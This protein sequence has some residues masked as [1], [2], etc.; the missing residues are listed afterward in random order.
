MH[1]LKPALMNPGHKLALQSYL[2]CGF[3]FCFLD[4]E[5]NKV[6]TTHIM[7]SEMFGQMTGC[8]DGPTNS[9]G[10]YRQR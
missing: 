4:P 7:F 5:I 2:L 3:L 1:L 6:I 8:G 10:S 9:F